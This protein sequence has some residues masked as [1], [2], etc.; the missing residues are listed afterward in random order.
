M[1]IF[2]APEL[3]IRKNGKFSFFSYFYYISG[4]VI[5]IRLNNKMKHP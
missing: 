1:L 3:Q 2:N 4:K 5:R